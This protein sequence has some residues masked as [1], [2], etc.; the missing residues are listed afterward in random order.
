MAINTAMCATLASRRW[1]AIGLGAI[2]V[3]LVWQVLSHSF[4]AYL[5]PIAPNAALWLRPG[6][7]V[8]LLKL[9]GQALTSEATT[10]L[11]AGSVQQP[12][13]GRADV[14]QRL[15]QSFSAFETVGRNESVN[16]P[17]LPGNAGV[18]RGWAE[19]ALRGAPLNAR[20]LQ[21]LGRLAEA[22]DDDK[23]AAKFMRASAHLSSHDDVVE[24]WLM[25]RAILDKNYASA[26]HYA[27]VLLRTNPEL[28]PDVVPVLG[29]VAED[30]AAR[31]LLDKILANNPPWRETFFAQL[32]QSVGDAR[33]PLAVLAALQKGATPPTVAEVAA[34]VD[35]LVGRKLFNLGYYTWLQLLPAEELRSAGLLFNGGFESPPSGLPFDWQI[36]QGSGVTIDIVPRADKG[37][38]H[39]LLV[40]FQF[41]RV[42]YHSV[43]QLVMLSP[44]TYE[45]SGD[46][47]GTLDGQRGLKWR[48]VCA[49]ANA[50]PIGESPMIMGLV[51]G[52]R[53]VGFTFTVPAA[54]CGAQYVRLDLDARTQSEELV[55]GSMLFDDLRI[56]RVTNPS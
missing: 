20:A 49:E 7:P 5:A 8:A 10:K 46:Y 50:A 6:Q 37:G 12:S 51:P 28:A 31:G 36:K 1:R 45:F 35:F 18:V 56:S 40:D 53:S 21:I 55:S 47:K 4:A 3:V 25:R 17:F 16:R 41:G 30:P 29:D 23:S 42:D 52:W 38:G 48:V 34:Y 22:E 26:I 27:D 11:P 39:A 19:A 2:A 44:G 9:A 33:L 54:G 13:S 24:F 32:P 15:N 14:G 43:T